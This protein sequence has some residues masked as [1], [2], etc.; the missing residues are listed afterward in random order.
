LTNNATYCA[1]TNTILY[2]EVFVQDLY[3]R[4]GDLSFGYPLASA[5][6]DA[7]QVALKSSLTGENRAL[8]NDCLV[9]TWIVDIVPS[10]EVA[11]DGTVLAKN[12]KQQILL[13]A[14][15]LDEAV[16]TAV[17]LGDETSSTDVAGTAF[18]KIDS[19]RNGVLGGM[20]ACQKRI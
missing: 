18:Q 19:F 14:G 10:G 17:A 20:A 7:V 9:G 13:S 16:V 12:P 15:D 2:D 1:D 4:L 6:S 11:A 5:Y 3:N 8:L